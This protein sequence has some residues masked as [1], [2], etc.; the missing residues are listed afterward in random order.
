MNL[1]NN[2]L[3][4]LNIL[5]FLISIPIVVVG[6]QMNRVHGGGE[7][8]ELFRKPVLI[9]G[10]MIMAMSVVGII[11]A[12]CR[13]SWVLW[14]YLFA[15][16][17]LIISL[18]IVYGIALVVVWNSG[19]GTRLPGTE[20]KEYKLSGYSEWLQNRVQGKSWDTVKNC[21]VVGDACSEMPKNDTALKEFNMKELNPV[22][23]GCC[24]P[25]AECEFTYQSPT[26]WNKTKN[27]SS[28]SD[29]KAWDNNPKVKCFDCNSC[30]AGI[31]E[32]LI[33]A[34]RK[35]HFFKFALIG[36]LSVIY[37]VGCCAFKESRKKPDYWR[38]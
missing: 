16:L 7:C 18:F 8:F 35:A 32:Q 33:I 34:W 2:L 1:P 14:I 5:T 29:C 23:S 11:G 20:L 38:Q 19:G 13:V 4:L 22:M 6:V 9:L 17:L 10:V 3:G 31:L 37:S 15:M 26:V 21:L 27:A 30:R 36:F 24:K 25:L 12:C 28:N